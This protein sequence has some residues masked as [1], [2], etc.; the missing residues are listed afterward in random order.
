MALVSIVEGPV[1]IPAG[2]TDPTT[3]LLQATE[4]HWVSARKFKMFVWVS[5]AMPRGFIIL[6]LHG[7]HKMHVDTFFFLQNVVESTNSYV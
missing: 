7:I 6:N 2:L 1:K 3:I 5:L 4:A